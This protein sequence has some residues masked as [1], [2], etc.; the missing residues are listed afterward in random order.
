[1][2]AAKEAGNMEHGNSHIE[3]RTR[4][5]LENIGVR[6]TTKAYQYLLFAL[7]QLQRDTP[8]KNTI[9]ELTA[10]H[11]GQT[12]KNVLACVNR[13]I[14]R[15]FNAKPTQFS[16]QNDDIIFTTCPHN[17]EFLQWSLT[18]LCGKD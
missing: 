12:R 5:Y 18:E 2:E 1:M 13:E 6:P 8:F 14:F 11:F 16:G 17:N 7:V 10:I 9:W 3:Q 4:S 15:A